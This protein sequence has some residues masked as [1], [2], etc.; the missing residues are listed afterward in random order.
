MKLRRLLPLL[1]LIALLVAPFGRMAAAEA[2]AMPHHGAAAPAASHCPDMPAPDGGDGSQ[3][4]ID[5]MIAC[6]AVTAADAPALAPAPP[7]R[8]VTAIRRVVRFSGLNPQADPPPPR[9]S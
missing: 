9:L 4:S 3:S 8:A 1:A 7:S 6:A 2:S 5:C